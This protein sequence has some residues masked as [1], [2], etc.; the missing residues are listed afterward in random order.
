MCLA[1][2]ALSLAKSSSSSLAYKRMMAMAREE[3]GMVYWGRTHIKTNR[4]LRYKRQLPMM[5]EIYLLKTVESG[6]FSC[7]MLRVCTAATDKRC[8]AIFL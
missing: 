2:Y 6:S 3:G 1:A 5:T 7:I 4:F 8:V